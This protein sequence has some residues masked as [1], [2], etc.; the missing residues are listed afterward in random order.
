MLIAQQV[1]PFQGIPPEAFA[2]IIAI[3]V[4]ALVIGL[5][6]FIMF[7]L[8]LQ[9]AL[10]QVAPRNREMEPGQVWLNFIPIF[11]FYWNFVTVARVSGSLRKEFHDRRLSSDD[12]TFAYNMG[13]S[14]LILN[15]CSLIPMIGGLF[16][17]GGLIC[18]II[19][20][21]KIS[22]FSTKLAAEGPSRGFDD[23]GDDRYRG[24]DDR[25]DDRYR[26][27]DRGDDRARGGD[28]RARGYESGYEDEERRRRESDDRYR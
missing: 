2:I 5:G 10:S 23:R 28:D 11:H 25:G 21:V 8:T 15:L 20:W 1:N 3:F 9:K 22:G 16:A 17:I 19:Y 24:G 4:I 7:L 12:D 27:G 6:I 18:F 14:W 13:L 26:G